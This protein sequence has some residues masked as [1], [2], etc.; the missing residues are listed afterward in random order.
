MRII[1]AVTWTL[2]RTGIFI[3]ALAMAARQEI[4]RAKRKT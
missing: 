1:M 2:A 3:S 4:P